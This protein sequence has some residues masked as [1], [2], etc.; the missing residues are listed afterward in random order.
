MKDSE[1]TA[2]QEAFDKLWKEEGVDDAERWLQLRIMRVCARMRNG[3][4]SYQKLDRMT[5]TIEKIVT[6]PG[7]LFQQELNRN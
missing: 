3:G 7:Y 6:Q 2:W 4:T 5:E 1:I